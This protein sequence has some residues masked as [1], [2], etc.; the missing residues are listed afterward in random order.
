MGM[1]SE[2]L[3]IGI[4]LGGTKIASALVDEDMKMIDRIVV[5]TRPEEGPGAV[6]GRM[7]DTVQDLIARKG[8]DA[9]DVRAIGIG[10]PGPLDQRTGAVLD[11]P[12]LMWKDVSL[13]EP[14]A[15][16]TGRPVYL[17]NDANVAA[18]AE[19]RLGAGRGAEHMMYITVSTGIGSGL[20]LG[21]KLYVGAAGAAGE[22]GHVTMLA[23][24]P[25]CR[26]GNRG[27]L[28]SLASGTAIA[29]RARE[30]AVR[31]GGEGITKAA[32]GDID[33]IDASLVAS[34]AASGDAAA[35]AIMRAAFEY[36]GIAVANVVNLLNL[37][38]VVIGGG[39][40]RVGDMLFDTVRRLVGLRA[41]A[42]LARGVAIVPASLGADV[43]ALG[44]A[45]YAAEMLACGERRG[46]GR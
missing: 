29:R 13:A 43:G 4:D 19:N 18:L 30:I 45:C 39:V 31:P 25:L 23:D 3:F 27:C 34:A 32:H 9:G 22:L 21:G 14:I 8:C 33:A 24:G 1:E 28:E 26:C 5:A 38:M 42:C 35:A 11:A 37:D 46:V 2:R 36:L 17:E 6:I 40:A 20:I 7:L 16:A 44:A 10:C 12:N 15:R 41:F